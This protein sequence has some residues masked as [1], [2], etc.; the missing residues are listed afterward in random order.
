MLKKFFQKNI[1]TFLFS[2]F[3]F[4]S[5]FL[6]KT[7]ANVGVDNINTGIE[8]IGSIVITANKTIAGPVILFLSG[9]CAVVFLYFLITFLIHRNKGDDTQL[10]KD[11][12][13]LLWSMVALFILVTIWGIIQIAQGLIGITDKDRDIRLPKICINDACDTSSFV[14]KSSSN[15]NSN[16]NGGNNSKNNNTDKLVIFKDDGA[17]DKKEVRILSDKIKNVDEDVRKLQEFLFEEGCYASDDKNEIDGRFATETKKALIKWQKINGLNPD[18]EF[19]PESQVKKD[20]PKHK[21]CKEKKTTAQNK[22]TNGSNP[23]SGGTKPEYFDVTFDCGSLTPC[24]KKQSVLKGETAVEPIEKPNGR[25]WVDP[26]FGINIKYFKITGNTKFVAKYKTPDTNLLPSSNL[27][28]T[29]ALNCKTYSQLDPKKC[30]T[31]IDG[32]EIEKF[33]EICI[34]KKGEITNK[35]VIPEYFDVTFDCGSLTPCPKKQRV[36]KGQKAEYPKE[37]PD[38][39]SDW[40]VPIL[41]VSIKN[42]DIIGNT[43]FVAKY[44]TPNTNLLPSSNLNPTTALNCK[45]LKI[46]DKSKCEACNIGY[47]L[48]A[49]NSQCVLNSQTNK[50]AIP[51]PNAPE[52]PNP[53]QNLKKP[54]PDSQTYF[55]VTFDCDGGKGGICG[56]KKV[57]KKGEE[58]GKDIDVEKP[59]RDGYNFFA[60]SSDEVILKEKDISKIKP[61][62]NVTFKAIWEEAPTKTE[63]EISFI[64]GEAKDLE[65]GY[66][67]ESCPGKKKYNIGSNIGKITEPKR[68]GYNFKGWKDE[69]GKTWNSL[70]SVKAIKTTFYTADWE[71]K[72]EFWSKLLN[73]IYKVKFDCTTFPDYENSI[74]SLKLG[75]CNETKSIVNGKKIG[76]FTEPK[77]RNG[78]YKFNGWSWNFGHDILDSKKVSEKIVEDDLYFVAYWIKASD[79]PK[80]NKKA[81]ERYPVNFN[82]N[83]GEG[84]ICGIK[85]FYKKGD[86]IENIAEPKKNKH[87]FKGWKNTKTGETYNLEEVKEDMDLIAQWEEETKDEIEPTEKKE[88]KT[89]VEL[90]FD[91]SGGTDCPSEYIYKHKGTKIGNITPPKKSGNKFKGWILNRNTK[92]LIKDISNID[93]ENGR[94]HFK[95]VWDN[96]EKIKDIQVWF[97]C[98]R[99]TGDFC[100]KIIKI[101]NWQEIV[102]FKPT[103]DGYRFLHWKDWFH[104]LIINDISSYSYSEKNSFEAVWEFIETE[105]TLKQEFQVW[106]DCDG[107]DVDGCGLRM[108]KKNQP[109][110]K[111]PNPTRGEGYKFGGWGYKWHG[112]DFYLPEYTENIYKEKVVRHLYYK[113][114]WKVK[115]SFNCGEGADKQDCPTD[116][117]VYKDDKVEEKDVPV[118]SSLKNGYEFITWVTNISG[119]SANIEDVI[120]NAPTT[121]KASYKKIV[122]ESSLKKTGPEQ[123]EQVT[124]SF[125]CEW[126]GHKSDCP[127]SIKVNVD[128]TFG[129]IK[130]RITSPTPKNGFSFIH[131]KYQ[132]NY[133]YQKIEDDDIIKNN[134]TLYALYE[135]KEEFIKVSFNCQAARPCPSPMKVQDGYEIDFDNIQKPVYNSYGE[136]KDWYFIFNNNPYPVNG[137]YKIN[138]MN[139]TK[140]EISFI[141]SFNSKSVSQKSLTPEDI[142]GKYAVITYS[143]TE[144]YYCY[145][146]TDTYRPQCSFNSDDM[147]ALIN[148]AIKKGRLNSSDLSSNLLDGEKKIEIIHYNEEYYDK[149]KTKYYNNNEKTLQSYTYFVDQT[150]KK[151]K[152]YYWEEKK[153][154]FFKDSN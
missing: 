153:V 104:N 64:C 93:L 55:S 81:E 79:E 65:S 142:K 101:K 60:W 136:F 28:L 125:N 39:L 120:I 105:E 123:Q 59:T 38:N 72:I 25:D 23:T 27:N 78:T 154:E 138:K 76:E 54:I 43:K 42:W 58:I 7:S 35:S 19:G 133:V 46:L 95:A 4:F 112:Y 57:V 8:N 44:K 12:K 31:C 66:V 140:K 67:V 52:S 121:F 144:K 14:K 51:N 119:Q 94:Y 90:Y 62:K 84:G 147:L 6:S 32:Y 118:I 83:G 122:P 33:S 148:I 150:Y 1:S 132:N 128:S 137:K 71:E 146:F 77:D 37:K 5:F 103:R 73:K 135:E 40:V 63:V 111:V 116:M 107:G 108:I 24:P 17:D 106:F 45:T 141:A 61:D 127:S 126:E 114:Y 3:Y 69:E 110:G 109:I 86:K 130:S 149:L 100:T 68:D 11:K 36:S 30:T 53:L 143:G 13:N 134:M 18:G 2:V 96:E 26:L 88:T 50:N 34:L 87:T 97:D 75:V 131:W 48:N 124:I 92:E 151:G 85:I 152:F 74:D 129:S 20:D 70:D 29:T 113:V 56:L 115:I 139:S 49:L 102:N 10:G 145:V 117:Y 41:G 89:D 98:D 16:N 21:P 82:C 15:N 47:Y 22:P 80:N 99:G 91:C 9:I